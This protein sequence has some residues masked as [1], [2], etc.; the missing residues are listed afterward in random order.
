MSNKL[1]SPQQCD[2]LTMAVERSPLIMKDAPSIP[3]RLTA[4]YNTDKQKCLG[5][6]P[7]EKEMPTHLEAVERLESAFSD[8]GITGTVTDLRLLKDS[9]VFY[10]HCRLT[11][12]EIDCS[13]EKKPC[14]ITPEIIL[15]N[16]FN[17]VVLFGLE[18]GIAIAPEAFHCRISTEPKAVEPYLRTFPNFVARIRE[19]AASGI[20]RLANQ[21]QIMQECHPEDLTDFDHLTAY[22]RKRWSNL[23][24]SEYYQ[25]AHGT[26][27]AWDR[28]LLILHILSKREGYTK[29]RDYELQMSRCFRL[30]WAL[31]LQ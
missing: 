1:L 6:V 11:E 28:F 4:L 15:R 29:R 23:M 7:S 2:L 19:F 3:T 14:I 10:L 9:S 21:I 26:V 22:T 25:G 24:L 12:P 30:I 31:Q 8:L 20:E 5:I 18:F 17:G 16:G 27:T 13:T